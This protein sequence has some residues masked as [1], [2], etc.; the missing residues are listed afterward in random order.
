MP[1][2]IA[3]IGGGG[4]AKEVI[5]VAEMLGHNIAGI[6]AKEMHIKNYK[7][8]GYLQELIQLKS[9]IDGVIIALGAVNQ[10]GIKNREKIIDNLK[11]EDIKLISIISPHAVIS[12]SATIGKGVY[13][14]HQTMLSSN[15][16]IGDNV[17]IN[18]Q[19]AIGHDTKIG[20]NVSISPQAFI[21][22]EVV[23]E[24][25]V[26]IGATAALKQGISVGEYATIGMKALLL[27]SLK[28]HGFVF[29]MPSRTLYNV[30]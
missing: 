21:G 24:N 19:V 17:C 27:K 7:H 26:M 12:P 10:I 11:K 28:A 22:G 5:E 3:I 13:I 30:T 25:H 23:V 1:K 2:N 16:Q 15:V 6:F 14:A 18:H 9:K 20:A 29:A 8:L 4:L